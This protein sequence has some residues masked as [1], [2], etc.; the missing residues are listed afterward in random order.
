MTTRPAFDEHPRAR[1]RAR[2]ADLRPAPGRVRARRG[3][4]ALGQR[5]QG[6]PRLPRRPRGHRARPRAPGGRRRARRAGPHAAARVE[7]LLQRVAAA[8]RGARSTRCTAAAARCSSPTRAP[9]P[10]SARSSSPAATARPTAAP[11][12]STCSRRGARSTAARSPR[13]P[14]PASR[15]SRRRSSRCPIGFRQVVFADLDALAAAMDERVCAVMLEPVQGEGGVQPSPPGLPR[16]R[17]RAVRRARGAADRR[18]GADRARPHRQVV[19]L[20]AR[21]RRAARHRHHGQGARQR[22]ADRRVLGAHR[23]RRGVQARR[24]R[25]HLRRAA[26]RGPRRARPC[27]T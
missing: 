23:G 20:P 8:G 3:R 17:A 1:R 2:H 19:R 7:P 9:R 5:G 12:G 11:T 25:H 26:A 4:E 21:R 14:P 15:R 27:S 13:S 24:P 6:V 16:R 10:T 22:R 18:R